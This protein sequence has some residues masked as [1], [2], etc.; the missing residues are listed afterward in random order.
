[1]SGSSTGY[2]TADACDLGE[3]KAI[4]ARLV[5][6]TD[7][8]HATGAPKNVPVYDVAALGG[9]FGNAD[10]RRVLMAEWAEI[11]RAG[12]GVFALKSACT[13]LAA[14]DAATA[15]FNDVIA[16][17]K[18]GAG[19]GADHFAAAGSNDRIWNSLQK[20]CEAAP[21]VFAHYHAS[22]AINAACEAWLGP[23]YQMTAQVNLVHPGGQ[24]QQA[25]RDYH[26]GF[27][28]AEISATYPAHVHDLSPLMTLQG[29]IAH[30]D[31]SIE[32]GPTKLL[33]F[34]QTYRPGYAA[35]RRDDFRPA[36]F[37]AAG[38]NTT[39]NVHRMVNLLQISSP[40]GRAMETVDRTRMCKTLF[41]VLSRA[42]Q[43]GEINE[44]ALDVVLSA[45]AEGYS[46]PTNLDRDPPVGGLAPLTQ[47]AAMKQ[48]I[49]ADISQSEFETTLDRQDGARRA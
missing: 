1:M 3:F 42:W 38:A 20:L 7:I 6:P 37:H 22:A 47:K 15:V 12:A 46:F 5:D 28:S 11:L 25:H 21:Q 35:W 45:T 44:A 31:I 14:I 16:A 18:A 30:C 19:G 39:S 33:P 34:S 29:G 8:P 2:Y 17:E 27:Q 49:M 36:L 24:P 9:M 41:P 4:T 40:F 26:L 43:T 48:A 23:N 13:D 10:Q 32:S